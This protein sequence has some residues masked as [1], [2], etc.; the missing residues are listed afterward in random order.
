M[1]IEDPKRPQTPLTPDKKRSFVSS[2]FDK[3]KFSLAKDAIEKSRYN[4]SILTQ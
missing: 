3:R 4:G 1:F 2:K